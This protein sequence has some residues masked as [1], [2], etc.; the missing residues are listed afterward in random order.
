MNHDFY[1]PAWA[2]NHAR[3]GDAVARFF[4]AAAA[5]IGGAFER[6]HAYQYDAPWRRTREHARRTSTAARRSI[7]WYW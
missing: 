3:L 5:A 4:G 1:G 6:L 2:D 7:G